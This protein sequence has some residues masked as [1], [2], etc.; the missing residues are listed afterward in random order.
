MRR[1]HAETPRQLGQSCWRPVQHGAHRLRQL[2]RAR[3]HARLAAQA[4]AETRPLRVVGGPEED[5]LRPRRP[6]RRAGGPA[7]DPRRSDAVDEP[8]VRAGVARQHGLPLSAHGVLLCDATIAT[9]PR[10][11]ASAPT[12]TRPT[13]SPAT[14]APSPT[15]TTGFT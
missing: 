6:A 8:A 2:R 1:A 5:D 13:F 10:M 3:P 14:S 15:A 12:A 11:S 7:V 4:G 9:P